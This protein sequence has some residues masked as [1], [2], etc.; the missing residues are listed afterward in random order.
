MLGQLPSGPHGQRGDGLGRSAGRLGDLGVGHPVDLGMPEHVAHARRQRLEGVH[1]KGLFGEVLIVVFAGTTAA[2]GTACVEELAAVPGPADHPV[3]LV[4]HASRDVG[5][6]GVERALPAPDGAKGGSEGLGHDVVDIAVAVE[7][8]ARHPSGPSDVTF[9]QQAVGCLV[10]T[11][12]APQHIGLVGRLTV[13]EQ[14]LLQRHHDAAIRRSSTRA[15]IIPPPSSLQSARPLY[16]P[17][18]I[19]CR[20][21]APLGGGDALLLLLRLVSMTSG[22]WQLP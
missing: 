22:P 14:W 1:Q 9:V 15:S 20:R 12:D 16:L 6:E 13:V 5:T 7:N 8:G 3:A 4:A 21:K 2:E 11:P 18:P 10:A 17:R 19:A